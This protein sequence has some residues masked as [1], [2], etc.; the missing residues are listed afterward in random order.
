MILLLGGTADTAPLAT[1]LAE[2]G[3]E[4]LVSTATGIPLA[5]GDHPRIRRRE[6]PLDKESLVA[7]LTELDIQAIIDAAHPYAEEV[8][9]NARAAAAC[10]HLP[11]LAYV[12]PAVIPPSSDIIRARNH[13]EAAQL[14]FALGHP[15]LLTT[16]S[17]NLLP[18][19]AA[20]AQTGIRLVVRVLD[21]PASLQACRKA[22]I[23][24]EQIVSGRGPFT[25]EQNVELI[26][27][28]AIGVVVTKDSGE[29]GGVEAKQEAARREGC[30]LVVVSRPQAPVQD[31]FASMDALLHALR[32]K[33]SPL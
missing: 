10:A 33:L 25:L 29:A 11:Y 19:A 5:V 6:G 3:Y 4:V 20:A 13:E 23:P 32:A 17:R 21:A 30:T 12:R 9:A 8:H 15:I 18:Y 24:P 26:R 22:G 31:A 1:L 28:F 2:A 27:R 16:G 14:A 7:L